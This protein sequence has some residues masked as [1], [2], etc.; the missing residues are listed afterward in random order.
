MAPIILPKI[1]SAALR[2]VLIFLFFSG[3]FSLVYT[4]SPLFTSNQNQY[5]LHGM[6]WAGVGGLGRDWLANTIDPTPVFSWMVSII[7]QVLNWPPIFYFLYAFLMGVYVLSLLG[8]LEKLFSLRA[9]PERLLAVLGLLLVVHSAILRDVFI[10]GIGSTWGFLLDGGVAGQRLLGLVFQPSSFGVFLLL[11]LYLFLDKHPVWAVFCVAVAATFHPTYLL[12]GGLLVAA[13]LIAD[14]IENRSIK[15]MLLVGGLALVFVMPILIYVYINF[16]SEPIAQAA[17]ARSIMVHQRIP[18]HAVVKE[19]L[20]W[21]VAIKVFLMGAALLVSR[22]DRKL[23]FV[24]TFLLVFTLGLTLAQVLTG[25]DTLAMLFPWRIS[26]LL[27]P[28]STAI[29]IGWLV[30]LASRRFS[31]PM[32]RFA[33]IWVVLAALLVSYG[34]IRMQYNQFQQETNYERG[35]ENWVAANSKPDDVYLVPLR[36]ET[37]RLMTNQPVYI[38]YMS[39]PYTGNEV[40]AW[41]GRVKSAQ[42]YYDTGNCKY[43]MDVVNDGDLTRVVLPQP[44]P[45]PTCSR[46]TLLYRDEYFAV[47]QYR[48]K[49]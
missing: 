47:Y 26:T 48:S 14:L 31:R 33:W 49:R 3:L 12:A 46:L 22:R 2:R 30:D 28:V 32:A 11:A 37:F 21:T 29:L 8:I 27:V 17:K 6:A 13:F 15:Q 45:G 35:M 16:G 18:Y 40:L 39:P 20:D 7:Y 4:Q 24:L 9:H 1:R 10:L 19:W 25:S 42:K 44:E 36:I 38:D 41:N 43:L 5:F 34:I 23:F